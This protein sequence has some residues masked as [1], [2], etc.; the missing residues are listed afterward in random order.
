MWC[1]GLRRDKIPLA[2]TAYSRDLVPF[3]APVVSPV[4]EKPSQ[5]LK[6]KGQVSISGCGH[7]ISKCLRGNDD[8]F[9]G[10]WVIGVK[11]KKRE[12]DR[13]FDSVYFLSGSM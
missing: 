2:L 10:E 3:D 11:V 5:V 1:G 9:S 12:C 13:G 6:G 8:C 4:G 7:A